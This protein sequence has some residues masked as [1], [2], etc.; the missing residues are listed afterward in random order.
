LGKHFLGCFGKSCYS[1]GTSTTPKD[2]HGCPTLLLGVFSEEGDDEP[3]E[4]LVQVEG[5]GGKL[6]EPPL[7]DITCL[8]V[9]FESQSTSSKGKW[10]L[11]LMKIQVG[12]VDLFER[13]IQL[14]FV[15]PFLAFF[16]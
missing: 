5:G 10:D 4:L 3:D 13:K 7:A 2:N 16:S 14:E 15:L 9:T 12:V 1:P 6:P 8:E 11:E